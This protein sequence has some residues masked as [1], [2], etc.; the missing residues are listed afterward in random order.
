MVDDRSDAPSEISESL[1]QRIVDLLEE[2]QSAEPPG[3]RRAVLA[4]AIGIVLIAAVI[5]F[6]RVHADAMAAA[7]PTVTELSPPAAATDVSVSG[8]VRVKF[9]RRP[10]GT[11][12]L[13]LEPAHA[14]LESVHWDGNTLVAVYSGL[15]LSTRYQLVLQADYHSRLK[16]VGHFEKRWTV[17]T[18]GYPVLSALTPRQDQMLAPRIGKISVDFSYRPPAEARLTIMPADGTW[19]PGQ[20]SG[21]TWTTSYTGL[22]PLTRYEVTLDVDYGAAAAS[23]RHHWA[24]S[25]EPGWPASS[26]PVIWYGM[27]NLWTPPGDQRLV[28]IDW[29]GNLAG[30]LYPTSV[31]LRQAPDGSAL[32][33]QDGGYVDGNVV[34]TAPTPGYPSIALPADDS[35]SICKLAGSGQ[36]WLES[37][38]LRG[39]MHRVAP[40]GSTGARSGVD[41]IACSLTSDR[42]V[43]ADNGMA[44]TTGIRVIAL[45]TGRLLYQRSYAG[46]SVGVT[47]SRDGRYVAEQITSVD[48]LGQP[49][50][51]FTLV[52]RINDGRIVARLDNQRVLRFSWDGMRVVTVPF[53]TGNVVKLIDWQT[54]K[55][56]WQQAGDLATDFRPAFA[57]AQPNGPAMAIALGSLPRTSDVDQ[58]W[59]V[60]ADG[61]AM[62]VLS[63]VFYPAF[64]TGL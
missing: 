58:L 15:R 40:A 26:V 30:S 63:T 46:S 32:L 31:V 36:L 39:P 35:K 50:A 2:E 47:S 33:T 6:V 22:K 48:A 52:R 45:S 38:P 61:Q 64:G 56:L 19:T 4:G 10:E 54:E 43:L 25:T 14:V 59:I 28:A 23:T 41:I 18:Q 51:A 1:H 20:W 34:G 9:G 29:Q 37:G 44:G 3:R 60:S 42:A 8:D 62:Q 27:K 24:F 49:S 12:T 55:V 17:T 16:D 13:R 53:F 5:A 7:Q 21:A 11:P 57:M